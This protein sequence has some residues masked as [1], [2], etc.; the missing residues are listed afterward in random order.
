LVNAS[1]ARHCSGSAANC[2]APGDLH[3]ELEVISTHPKAFIIDNYISSFEADELIRLASLKVSPSYVGN[4]E[5][6]GGRLSST[7]TS[8]NTWLKRNVN[9]ITETIF[10]R[11]AD[12][13]RIEESL[14]QTDTMVEEMQLVKY[15]KGQ[16]YD[17]HHDWGVSGYPESRCITV[18][19]Y[20][21]DMP[22]AESGGETSFPK[23]RLESLP[24]GMMTSEIRGTGV[25]VLPKKGQAMMFYNLL[26]DGNGDDLSLHAAMP[27]HEGVKWLANFW[28]WDP[29]RKK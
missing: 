22:S 9:D 12:L 25:K 13:L 5:D 17:S 28:V 29:S 26:E 8:R 6:G 16:K 21:N 11:T 2:Q 18:L 10:H 27:V 14:F 23:A 3:L 15:E 19:L 24:P 20:L 4:Q 1:S 7:R